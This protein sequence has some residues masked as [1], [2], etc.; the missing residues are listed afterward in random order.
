MEE[1]LKNNSK[2]RIRDLFFYLYFMLM[3]G[4]RMWGVYESKALYAPLIVLAML[5]WLLSCAM[6]E[7]SM[8]EYTWGILLITLAAVVYIK[9][10][11]KGLIF[12]FCLLFGMKGVNVKELF[13]WGVIAGASGMAVMGFLTTFGIVE[14]VV[15]AQ[16]RNFVGYVLR[17]A[18]GTPHPNT[19]GTSFTIVAIMIL[20]VIGHDNKI[21]VWRASAVLF[22]VALYIYIF[23]QS[24]TAILITAGVLL[25]NIIY[26]YRNR[27]GVFEKT[28]SVLVIPMIV[29]VTVLIPVFAS[30]SFVEKINKIDYF[31]Y[32]RFWHGQYYLKSNDIT[33]F[34]QRLINP[35]NVPTGIDISMLYLILQLGLVAFIVMI[36]IWCLLI[37]DDIK[38]NKV[39]ELIIVLSLLVMGVTDPFLYNIS[40][41]NIAFAFMGITMFEYSRKN[42]TKLPDFWGREFSI[43]K[44]MKRDVEFPFVSFK[45]KI[46][47]RQ[48]NRAAVIIIVVLMMIVASLGFAFTPDPDYVLLDRNTGEH[49]L[50]KELTGRTYSVKE[51]EEIRDEGNVVINYSGEDEIMYGYYS[52]ESAPV[53]GGIWTPNLPQLEKIRFWLAVFVWGSMTML[54]IYEM[55]VTGMHVIKRKQVLNNV[56]K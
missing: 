47:K 45:G 3:F 53:K 29:L 51:I 31:L 54:V 2:V 41:K 37:Y 24:R 14:D 19:L 25:I 42:Q 23:A 8:L 27:I 13:R 50:I 44:M 5:L 16:N 56:G 6:T 32:I 7:Y 20:Y 10:G 22:A 46:V 1:N 26:T 49:K 38:H 15:Y 30:E 48:T 18:L 55:V 34:G 11:E 9:T 12:Y 39:N 43:L 36:F 52:R 40:F 4:M 21:R 28:I 17:H 35:D 33:L